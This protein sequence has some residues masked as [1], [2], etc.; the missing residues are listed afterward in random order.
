MKKSDIFRWGISLLILAFGLLSHDPKTSTRWFAIAAALYAVPLVA[1]LIPRTWARVYGIYFGLFVALQAVISANFFPDTYIVRAPHINNYLDIRGDNLHGISGVQHMTTDAK[2]FRTTKPVNY[3]AKADYRIFFIGASTVAQDWIGDKQTFP[4][5]VQ[6]SLSA[7]LG[8][9]IE[10]INTAVPGLRAV[11]HL[12]TMRKVADYHPNMYVIVPGANDWGLHIT[13]HY[14]KGNP[15]QFAHTTVHVDRVKFRV[16]VL[17]FARNYTL[18]HTILGRGILPLWALIKSPFA[19]PE[20][21]YGDNPE[22]KVGYAKFYKEVRGS[23]FRKDKRTFKPKAVYPGYAKTMRD[24][25][26]FCKT[27][28]AICVLATHPHS[29]KPGTTKAYRERFWMTPAFEKYTLTYESMAHIATLYNRFTA[30]LA[31]KSGLPFCDLEAQVAPSLENFYDEIH[32]NLEG[33][34]K[35]A[36]VLHNCLVKVIGKKSSSNKLSGRTTKIGSRP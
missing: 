6:E 20:I 2:G 26:A 36:A 27:S 19:S 16:G 17:E 1:Q 15:D 25:V 28:G 4:H 14:D 11:H 23:L 13:L 24:I 7:K 22:R 5:L 32:Y 9:N 31:K 8:R 3:D 33:S 30:E 29:F 12:A 21:G 34:R 18:Q 10:A 35:A